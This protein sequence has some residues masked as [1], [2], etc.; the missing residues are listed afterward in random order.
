M[1]DREES[2]ENKGLLVDYDGFI[3]R[4]SELAEKR[5]FC[6]STEKSCEEYGRLDEGEPRED[7]LAAEATQIEGDKI[8]ARGIRDKEEAKFRERKEEELRKKEQLRKEEE[9][10]EQN[11]N[12]VIAV[13]LE[14]SSS[15]PVRSP[16]SASSSA[17]V[18]SPSSALPPAPSLEQI[19]AQAAQA[20]QAAA[21]VAAVI[22]GRRGAAAAV[23]GR[24]GAAAAAAA[25]ER[26]VAA[27]DGGSNMACIGTRRSDAAEVVIGRRG[28]RGEVEPESMLKYLPGLKYF[29]Q[30]DS[31]SIVQPSQVLDSETLNL[32]EDTDRTLSASNRRRL[33]RC[34]GCFSYCFK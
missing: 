31:E 13:F 16:S 21:R 30:N 19:T 23:R 6:G 33:S 20:A 18:R 34:F 8:F 7:L 15:A 29:N 2:E 28:R 11:L 5:A 3:E 32:L 26:A 27:G 14:A 10:N 25:A 1:S 12:K 9:A 22:I 4:K 24:R 17:P